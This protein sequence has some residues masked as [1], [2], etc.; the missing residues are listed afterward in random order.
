MAR[1]TPSGPKPSRIA[2]TIRERNLPAPEHRKFSNV[3]VRV[4]PAPL[5]DCP[6]DH[7]P[8]VERKPER[9][10]PQQ[11]PSRMESTSG[12]GVNKRAISGAKRPSSTPTTVSTSMLYLPAML[13]RLLGA[14]RLFRAER[15][16]D[17]RRRGIR[18]PDAGSSA[19]MMTRM[20]IV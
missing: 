15:L 9:D 8:S 12:F 7:P 18:Q 1:K 19:N 17:H 4:S 16:T 11:R 3:G 20:P 14:L 10:D 2:S 13:H 6:I 5:N